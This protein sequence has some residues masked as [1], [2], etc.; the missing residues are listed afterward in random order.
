VFVAGGR[1]AIARSDVPAE[2]S[3]AFEIGLEQWG[4]ETRRE[5]TY[6]YRV[7]AWGGGNAVGA[8]GHLRLEGESGVVTEVAR[9]GHLFGRAAP[10]PRPRSRACL[11]QRA[12]ITDFRGFREATT[13]WGITFGA[14]VIVGSQP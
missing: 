9:D 3:T 6:R 4:Y 5:S 12:V 7:D 2:E 13:V 10:K 1:A 8:A 11:D 14:G